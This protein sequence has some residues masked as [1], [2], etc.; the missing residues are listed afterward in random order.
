MMQAFTAPASFSLCVIFWEGT[1]QALS[2]MFTLGRTTVLILFSAGLSSS[3]ALGQQA[4]AAAAPQP[5]LTPE[6][7]LSLAEQGHCRESLSALKRAISSQVSAA[8]KKEIGVVGVR[9]SLALDDQD[10]TL[11]FLRFL[12]KQFPLDPDVLFVVTHAYSDLST[13]AA[14]DLGRTAPQSFAAHKLNAEALE[15]Q[16]KWEPAQ[17][18]YEWMIQKDP[19]APGIHFLLARLLL[20]RPD[21]GPDASEKAKQELLKETQID[22]NN[23]GAVYILGELDRRDQKWDDAISRYNQA[24]KVDPNFGEAYLGLGYC[25]VNQKKYEEAIPPLRLAERFMPQNPEVHHSLGTA[26]QRT[27]HKEEAQKEFEIHEALSSAGGTQKSE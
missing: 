25:L 19:S 5:A 6:K 10:S 26:L 12:H 4:K 8:S 9:C 18:E 20:S 16:G 27:G 17:A 13:R 1:S 24:L 21:A 7:A 14:Q 23:A 2:K 15:M 22:P 3:T 11:D